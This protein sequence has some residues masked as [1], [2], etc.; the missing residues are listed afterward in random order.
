MDLMLPTLYDL[1]VENKIFLTRSN[2]KFYLK[3]LFNGISFE[4]RNVLDIGGG[5]GW[6]SFYSA[7]NGAKNAVCLEPS[8]DGSTK[9]S[10]L[11]FKKNKNKLNINSATL[12]QTKIEDYDSEKKFDIVIMNNSINHLVEGDCI[13]L[14]SDSEM[15]MKVINIFKKVHNLTNNNATLVIVDYSKK[16]FFQKLGMTNHPLHPHTGF[17][18]HETPEFW[19]NLIEQ[20]GYSFKS[21]DW[22]TP[23]SLKIFGKTFLNNYIIANFLA[24]PFKISFKVNKFNS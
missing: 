4:N 3:Q 1:C 10:D 17:H 19:I 21:I 2:A 20:Y 9:G 7:L 24:F 14:K 23:N 11:L 18:D 16:H 13:N 5:S 8:E 12:V 22:V 15:R 6:V